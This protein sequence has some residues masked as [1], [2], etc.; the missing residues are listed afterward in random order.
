MQLFGSHRIASGMKNPTLLLLV[1]GLASATGGCSTTVPEVGIT[2]DCH[3]HHQGCPTQTDLA[4]ALD[5]FAR[6]V[7]GFDPIAALTIEWWPAS[8]C[9]ELY[10]DDA[11]N[12]WCRTGY[13]PAGDH[14]VVRS[15]NALA[16]ELLHAHFWR[17]YGDGDDNHEKK[18]GP[19]TAATY[20]LEGEIKAQYAEDLLTPEP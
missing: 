15:Y 11:G 8:T 2:L 12:E 14:V 1:L 9:F 20:E 7:D 18:P 13:A 16:H 3:V 19:W 17:K 6:K 10:T 4:L 5:L